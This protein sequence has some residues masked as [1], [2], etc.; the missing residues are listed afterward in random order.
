MNID[1]QSGDI[2][3]V[4]DDSGAVYQI[5]Y[6]MVE[7]EL[8]PSVMTPVGPTT[9]VMSRGTSSDEISVEFEYVWGE[10]Y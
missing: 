5:N 2:I 4:T 3:T 1:I 10:F 7:K 6:E 8:I 9:I